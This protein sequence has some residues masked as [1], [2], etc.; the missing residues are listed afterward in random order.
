[1]KKGRLIINWDY[2][3][4]AGADASILGYKDG[5]ED[6]Y[7]TEFILN[8][9]KNYPQIKTCFAVLGRAA[10]QGNLPYHAPEQIKQMAEEGHEVGSH[11]Y[12]HLRISTISY[13]ELLRELIESKKII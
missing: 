2:E 12:N 13:Q 5:I 3:L 8:F 9:L 10:E 11:T 1:M 4:Q 6:Y 7:Q